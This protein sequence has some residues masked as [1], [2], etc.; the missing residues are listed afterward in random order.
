MAYERVGAAL[1]EALQ[2][3]TVQGYPVTVHPMGA[4]KIAEQLLQRQ[5]ALYRVLAD[6]PI[7]WSQYSERL[8]LSD[9]KLTKAQI[10]ERNPLEAEVLLDEQ[11]ERGLSAKDLYYLNLKRLG[12]LDDRERVTCV[13]AP[14]RNTTIPKLKRNMLVEYSEHLGGVSGIRV[15]AG[16][17]VGFADSNNVVLLELFEP[18]PFMRTPESVVPE[19]IKK[20]FY[21]EVSWS[22]GYG[23]HQAMEDNAADLIPEGKWADDEREYL[24]KEG[25]AL[26]DIEK[27][28]KEHYPKEP[29]CVWHGMTM[30]IVPIRMGQGEFHPLREDTV[31]YYEGVV[32][33]E[34][35]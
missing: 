11:I 25:L 1:K 20:G 28:C 27:F 16:R 18:V 26:K 22:L 21:S 17:I 8:H 19:Q 30:F 31:D 35:E 9:Q 12:C 3:Y 6:T 23:L 2:N 10:I 15:W 32:E 14:W 5:G 33:V 4:G 34:Y 7:S 24:M 29:H 13:V